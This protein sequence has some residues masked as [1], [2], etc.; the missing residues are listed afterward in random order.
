MIAAS[1]KSANLKDGILLPTFT[2][3][4][5]KLRNTLMQN[6]RGESPATLLSFNLNARIPDTFSTH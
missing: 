2:W 3:Q 4:S 5:E 1:V 6:I